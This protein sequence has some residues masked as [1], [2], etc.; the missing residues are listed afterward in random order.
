MKINDIDSQLEQFKD[1][2]FVDDLKFFM[3]ND[4]RFYRKVLY[5]VISELRNKLKSGQKCNE[6]S[7]MNCIER[8]IPVYCNKFKI[9]QNPKVIFDP[10]E[11]KDLAVRM[12]HEEKQNINNGVYDGRDE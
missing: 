9:T 8:A 11:V 12:F 4:P 3:H 6:T 7:F 1:V 10:E 5:P 2:D